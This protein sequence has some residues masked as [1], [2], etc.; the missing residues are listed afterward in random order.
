MGTRARRGRLALCVIVS[1]AAAH[2]CARGGAEDDGRRPA[3][4]RDA[5]GVTD[6]WR[7]S[8]LD[9]MAAEARAPQPMPWG[10]ALRGGGLSL[11]AD[12]FGVEI[13]GARFETGADDAV[14]PEAEGSR[15]VYRR[16]ALTEWYEARAE[17]IEQGFDVYEAPPDGGD[18]VVRV[19]VDALE[20]PRAVAGGLAFGEL[21]Y[22]GLRAWDAAGV[23][24]AGAIAWDAAA[25]EIVLRVD[26]ADASA[27]LFPVTLDPLF[28][29]AY[30]TAESNQ[31]SASF[32]YS[33]AFA[34]D[35]N[36]DGF[37]DFLVGAPYY[38]NG[39]TDEGRALLFLGSASG[40]AAS[41]SWTGEPD[42]ANAYYGSSVA[43]A[44]DVNGDGYADVIVGAPKFDSG[45]LNE[46]R[47]YLYLGSAAG[48][49]A[50]AAW[51]AESNQ[52]GAR[53][54]EA[55]ASAGDVNGDGFADVLVGAWLYDNGQ[56]DEGR[57]YLYVGSATGLAAT[58]AWT[59]EKDQADAHFGSAVSSAGDVNGDGFGDVVV[60]A[61]LYDNGEADEGQLF[62]YLGSAAGLSAVE[63]WANDS[64]QAF[65]ELGIA[66]SSAGDVNGD[67]FGD[68][69]AG[70]FQY[71]AGEADEGRAYVY[72]G[73]AT[74]LSATAAWTAES[75][76]IAAGFGQAVA[77][78][79]DVNGDGFGDVVVGA[80][81]F[82]SGETNEGR[83][84]LYLGAATGL[85]TLPAW[86]AEPNQANA[87][88]GFS[89]AAAGDA[90]GD[91]FGDVV[92][93][94]ELNDA[95]ETD[96]GRSYLYVGLATGTAATAAWTAESNQVN[97]KFA[98]T[99]ITPINPYCAVAAA[100]D[101]NGDGLGDV[102]V[103]APGYD[104]GQTDEGRAFV[105]HG[106]ASGLATASAWIAESNQ[107]GA[108]FGR[109]VAAAGDVNGDGFADVLVGAQ[110]FDNGET[111][112]GRAFL[113][114]GSAA[115]LAATEA[116]TAEA[117][118]ANANF[119][120]ALAGAGDVNGDG[121][122]DVIV[123]AKNFDN[124]DVDEGRAY[125][126]LGSAA[127]LAATPAWTAET[128]LAGGEF[129][130]AVA[131]AGDVNG[132]GFGDV[133]VGAPSL[134]N[135]Q[136][137]EGRAYLYVGSA[138]GLGATAS[139]TYEPNVVAA[140]FGATVSAAGDVN[141]DGYGDVLIG[142]EGTSSTYSSEGRASLF[143]GWGGAGGLLPSA[144]WS[145]LG[146]QTLAYL[147][148]SVAAAGDVNGDRFADVLVGAPTYDNPE[149]DEGIAVV[150]LGSATGLA[151]LPLRTLDSNQ[152]GAVL[153]AGSGILDANG[154]GFGDV[155][156]GAAYYG[157][158]EIQEGRAFL[159]LGGDGAPGL[160]RGLM[161]YRADGTTSIGVGGS[162]G[163]GTVLLRGR[164]TQEGGVGGLLRL[165]V[166]VKPSNVL[167][168]GT[169]TVFSAPVAAGAV[170][171][172]TVSG[173]ALGAYHWRARVAYPVEMGWGRWIPFGSNP[174]P[175]PDF[176]V[177]PF[178]NGV[179]C[180]AGAV[181]A[182][183]SCADGVC[184]DTACGGA[185]DRCDLVPGVCTDDDAA[186]TGN[187][188]VC[189]AGSCGP[190]P[191]LCTG[192]CDACTGAGAT[193]N[194]AG[195][196]TQCP[197]A[198]EACT[199][200]GTSFSCTFLTPTT[201]CRP[202]AG[203]CDAA[204]SCTGAAATCPTDAFVSGTVCRA[205]AG[206][207]DVAES[208]TGAAAACPADGFAPP[209]TSCRATA[210]PCDVAES[211]S[212]VGPACPADGFAPP[213]TSCRVAAGPCDVSENCSG[214]GAACPAD[215]FA[216]PALVC[217]VSA[218]TCD[219]AESCP[220][221]SAACPADLVQ[222][223][224]LTCRAAAA[225][226]D[227]V[228]ACDGVGGACPA[229][230]FAS[231]GTP[232]RTAAGVCDVAESCT[233]L[234]PA[235]PADAFAPPTT[236][237]RAAAGQCDAAETCSGAAASCPA[238]AF[239]SGPCSDGNACT[240][241]DACSAG[242]CAPGAPTACADG[243]P[244]TADACDPAVGCTT[245]ASPLEGAAC[246]DGDLCTVG[247]TC[248]GG[249]CGGGGPN[250]C[251]DALPCTADACDGAA[252]ACTNAPVANGTPCA[253]AGGCL[254]GGTCTG[255]ACSAV[256]PAPAGTPCDDANACTATDVCDGAGLCAGG[257]LACDGFDP[258][259]AN[260]CDAATGCTF[261]ALADG[262]LCDDGDACTT[263]DACAGGV[264]T[265]SSV[266]GCGT[267]AGNGGTTDGGASPS[268]AAT[269]A[270]GGSAPPDGA[271]ADAAFAVDA[272][273]PADTG[274]A[275]DAGP[276]D[277]RGCQC[278]VVAA[279]G[280]PASSS[281]S[282]LLLVLLALPIAVRV[283]RRRARRRGERRFSEAR[284]GR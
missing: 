90:N 38:D 170:A 229:D 254:T 144:S 126:Y 263:A 164:V 257:A 63:A 165:E 182:S 15:V 167:F 204:E 121:F 110:L 67:G 151:T 266:A 52:A 122:A 160:S 148:A 45:E 217:R 150:H 138:A 186:C 107:V 26:G 116:W 152:V 180:S 195:D 268:D 211:C 106:T 71:D 42:Q 162:A 196:A 73:S 41:P 25:G 51:T 17:G 191:A 131:S 75:N 218:G 91:G 223:T 225:F 16:A 237:C 232:C 192:G 240:S 187:C 7:A 274:V 83:A 149:V 130:A 264:C 238:D 176:R 133:I 88:F 284:S 5:P 4:A 190:D 135:G 9:W 43:G 241:G 92:V 252:Q 19:A 98:A 184:C 215:G 247:E 10:Y 267:D 66:A 136:S 99:S 231:P 193:F 58:A 282:S 14:V 57:A 89:V 155:L 143:L 74:G 271:A 178:A 139:W 248:I 273:P 60:G 64:D 261:A 101:V 34:G 28:G 50:T 234:A 59:A 228:E 82:D 214:T 203:V 76:Q 206:A 137:D 258:C 79:G 48:L 246:D 259:T 46:G 113:Y 145:L 109:C 104:N 276:S 47:A 272:S 173:L 2:A 205:A 114:L 219:V 127:G 140:F 118:Q 29:P 55:V 128:N 97:A 278:R 120:L 157:N 12:A 269:A 13:D 202:A 169:G 100:G 200:G 201:V 132:D 255:G 185:C 283:R 8:T 244:C 80:Y 253:A 208:C 44:G 78:A 30:W 40:P 220:G 36:G 236:V 265:G 172:A 69:A 256:T 86:T 251:S 277:R 81:G 21:R 85:A 224:G 105:Y 3:G 270:D 233:G 112:E 242:A 177:L 18:L 56:S 31:V 168:D 23:E 158:G 20:S 1:L 65:A 94:A 222:P 262:T 181:C 166:E 11:R 216:P 249:A 280:A 281:A 115:G 84:F 279:R 54:A 117:D 37:G 230:G 275:S 207:C 102:I 93:G 39:Q 161:Q 175:D 183:G 189:T 179:A 111:D 70:A 227:V 250:G 24:L 129:G 119:G 198:C 35:V 142:A 235:C 174:E 221:A 53:F 6:A 153:G 147:G 194:C 171:T 156:L 159:Y 68:V 199:G 103:G 62:V 239:A 146:S 124:G 125:V 163:G 108:Q 197:G 61:P 95:G 27:A 87:L 49:A 212:G 260:G 243:N 72:L 213:G 141:G 226:C 32:G 22:T 77:A 134:D 33:V 123:G 210:G 188:A 245:D 96:E 209:S 154:D